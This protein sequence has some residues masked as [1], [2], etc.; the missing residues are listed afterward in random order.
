MWIFRQQKGR[1]HLEETHDNLQFEWLSEPINE[2]GRVDLEL[3][4]ERLKELREE[5]LIVRRPTIPEHELVTIAKYAT[6]LVTAIETML[7][8]ADKG[9]SCLDGSSEKQ[10]CQ[11]DERYDRLETPYAAD[12]YNTETCD[13]VKTLDLSHFH[14]LEQIQSPYQKIT[15][16]R[17]PSNNNTCFDLD[18]IYQQCTSY[19]P[20]YHEIMVHYPARF[21]PEVKRVLWVGGGDSMLL[22]E[23]LKYPSIELVVGLELDQQ[24]T[25]AA[26]KYFGSQP[27]WNHEK[28]Q[29]WYGDAAKSLLM[30][31]KDY[32]GTFDLVLVDLSETVMA[33]TVSK[34]LDIMGALSLLLKP[35]GI[36]VKNEMYFE[37]LSDLFQYTLQLHFYDVPLV[38]SQVVILGS[39]KVDF[40]NAELHDHQVATLF[41]Q[42]TEFDFNLKAVHDYLDNPDAKELC[43]DNYEE[44]SPDE[45]ESSPGIVMI[46]E[47]EKV[48]IG[49]ETP[50]ELVSAIE[51]ALQNEDFSVISMTRVSA[52]TGPVVIAVLKEGYIAA[53]AWSSNSYV[54]FDI[55]LWASFHKLEAIQGSLTLAVGSNLKTSSLRIVATGMFGTATFSED[56][57]KRGPKYTETCGKFAVSRDGSCTFNS[58]I[59][60]LALEESLRSLSLNDT[61]SIAVICGSDKCS[62][63]DTIRN[64]ERVEHVIPL[65]GT[66][67]LPNNASEL[68][69]CERDILNTLKSVSDAID[70]LVLDASAP[71]EMAQIIRKIISRVKSKRAYFS[72]NLLVLA[73]IPD[74]ADTWRRVFVDNMRLFFRQEPAFYGSIELTDEQGVSIEMDIFSSGDPLFISHINQ[75]PENFQSKSQLSAKVKHIGGTAF[76]MQ[77][78]MNWTQ[79]FSHQDYAQE[80]SNKQWV[81]Q[82]PEGL[83]TIFQFSGDTADLSRQMLSNL[84]YQALSNL[85]IEGKTDVF[86][87]IGDGSVTVTIWSEGHAVLV[88]DGKG[89]VGMNLFTYEENVELADSFLVALTDG[90]HLEVALRDEMPRGGIAVVN[91]RS[92]IQGRNLPYFAP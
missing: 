91:K 26:F 21:L 9:D 47:A 75:I 7:G 44:D 72:D 83:Q 6:A 90:G 23:I 70:V 63:L 64:Y 61:A 80:S 74:K 38:C 82:E 29:W 18:S 45:S 86:S 30:L 8:V 5:E 50:N 76:T 36:F 31:P 53:R 66:H 13:A 42:I 14:V 16:L 32:F 35:E 12:D 48:R 89:G 73:L 34:D 85:G 52:H 41:D 55:H 46:L 84:H 54:A 10:E 1:F 77:E 2:K 40:I 78:D 37:R 25:R 4:L 15:Y 20:H 17:D 49:L 57:K 65:I 62:A 67:F 69:E 39:R 22:H 88:W 68:L 11:L 79:F 56:Y 51:D 43:Q 87:D 28:V 59:S 33:N 58:A 19:R 81:D 3:Q 24:V 92:D 71:F 27:H 60:D